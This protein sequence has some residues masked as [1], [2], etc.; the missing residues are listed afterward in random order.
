M[1]VLLL[2]V[3]LELFPQCAQPTSEDGDPERETRDKLRERVR[4]R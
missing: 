2:G 3:L 4:E 1:L